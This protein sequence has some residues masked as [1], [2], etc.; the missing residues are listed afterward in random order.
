MASKSSS[1]KQTRA[2][3]VEAALPVSVGGCAG[4]TQNLST[5]GLYVELPAE[6][7]VGSQV[8]CLI[9]LAINGRTVQVQLDAEVVRV[10]KKSGRTGLA[11]KIISQ[12]IVGQAGEA[13]SGA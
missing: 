8:S 10:E 7:K 11:L 13:E 1:T 2:E 4:V 6:Q 12:T 5:T 9:D 3:R